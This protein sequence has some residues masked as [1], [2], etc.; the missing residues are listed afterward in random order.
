MGTIRAQLSGSPHTFMK[1]CLFFKPINQTCK[2]TVNIKMVYL[3]VNIKINIFILCFVK[4]GKQSNDL[5]VPISEH[6]KLRCNGSLFT[7][8]SQ[9]ICPIPTTVTQLACLPYGTILLRGTFICA[10]VSV[11]L[12]LLLWS[13]EGLQ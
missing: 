11:Q 13:L 9:H 12:L 2:H 1:Y 6:F 4:D 3:Y 7:N 8:Q 5:P 10:Y